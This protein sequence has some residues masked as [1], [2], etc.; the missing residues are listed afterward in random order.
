VPE[1]IGGLALF[2]TVVL[3]LLERHERRAESRK[4]E[5]LAREVAALRKAQVELLDRIASATEAIGSKSALEV[6]HEQ[7]AQLSAEVIHLPPTSWRLVITN[8]GPGG[9]QLRT[10]HSTNDPASIIEPTGLGDAP[11][12]LLPGEQ[13][14][15]VLAP[16]GNIPW[17]LTI[18]TAWVDSRGEKSREQRLMPST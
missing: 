6:A 3:W 15:I 5:S 18:Q 14:T 17:P 12:D 7:G 9:A 4:R 2:V 10:V 1:A 8:T 13:H 11:I 16:S